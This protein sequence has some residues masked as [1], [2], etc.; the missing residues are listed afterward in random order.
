M[1]SVVTVALAVDPGLFGRASHG[2][3]PTD[4]YDCTKRP[5]SSISP[6][7]WSST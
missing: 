7:L 4:S 2:S 6:F 1:T 5:W 3:P